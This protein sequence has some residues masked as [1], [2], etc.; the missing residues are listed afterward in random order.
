MRRP[1]NGV[2]AARP[3]LGAATRRRGGRG[4]AMRAAALAALFAAGIVPTGASAGGSSGGTF[5]FDGFGARGWGTAGAAIAHVAGADAVAWNPA[6]LARLHRRRVSVSTAGLVEGLTA[7]RTQAAWAQP[8][9]RNTVDEG[10]TA[11]HAVGAMLSALR[12]DAAGDVAYGEYALRLAW[13]FTP[14]P[15]VTLGVAFDALA[16]SSDLDA[17]DARGTSIDVGVRMELT[18]AVTAAAVVRGAFSRIAFDDGRD[19]ERERIVEL[20]AAW[21]AAR[22]GTVEADVVAAW[23]GVARLVVG[24]ESRPL[25][26]ILVLRGGYARRRAGDSRGVVHAGL[27]VSAPGGRWRLD[28]AAAFDAD[29]LGTTHRFALGAAW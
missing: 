25:A 1:R 14:D 21:R 28:Y 16:A 15:F 10:R 27:G 17:F 22:L 19:Q 24:A 18:D 9:A 29:A 3:P 12:L 7:R 13:A 8:L 5:L 11:R 6:M 2:D 20:G 4:A 23:G 26:G